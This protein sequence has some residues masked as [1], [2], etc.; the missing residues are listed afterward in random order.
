M[1]VTVAASAI[2]PSVAHECGMSPAAVRLCDVPAGPGSEIP[3]PADQTNLI[4]EW[5]ADLWSHGPRRLAADRTGRWGLR[6]LDSSA[7]RG[8][9]LFHVGQTLAPGGGPG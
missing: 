5:T 7:P 8:D 4:I 2:V 9:A 1:P 6:L 3:G